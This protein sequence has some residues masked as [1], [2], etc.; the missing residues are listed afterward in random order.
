MQQFP[1]LISSHRRRKTKTDEES[2]EGETSEGGSDP[3]EEEEY[4]GEVELNDAEVDFVFD[5]FYKKRE[6]MRMKQAPGR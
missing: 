1:L 6:T 3:A 2:S 5:E 4:K